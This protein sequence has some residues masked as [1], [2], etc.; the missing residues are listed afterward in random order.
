MVWHYGSTE[1]YEKGARTTA[2]RFRRPAEDVKRDMFMGTTDVLVEKFRKA[3]D[4]GV[5]T[6]II[7]VRPTG[8]VKLAKENL[9]R[10]RDE[11]ISQL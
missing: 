7:F 3:G 6:M 8:D 2:E 4:M 1:E 10:F 5:D 11:V 9:G